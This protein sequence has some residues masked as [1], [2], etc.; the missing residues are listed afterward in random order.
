MLKRTTAAVLASLLLA[1]GCSQTKTPSQREEA[2]RN[3]N[4]ARAGVLI[5]LANDQFKSG[6]FEKCRQTID[7]ALKLAPDNESLHVLAAKLA[8]E[9]GQPEYADRE[10]ALARRLAPDDPEPYYLAGVI[11][12]RWQKYELAYELY[13][14]AS[15]KA[16][17]E[18]AYLLAEG[19]MLVAM[20]RL[21][22]AL[23]L[24]QEKVVY[25]EH[26]PT[27]RD[28]A[29]QLLLQA[30]RYR[31][32]V[33]MFRQA[34][35]LSE[36]DQ[37]VRERL[38]LAL[39]YAREFGESAEILVRLTQNDPYAKRS[40]LFLVLGE[41]QIQGGRPREARYSFQ[42][43]TQLDGYSAR[44]WQGLG[45]AALECGDLRRAEL[46]LQKATTLDDVPGEAHLLLGYVRLRQDRPVDA[47]GEFQK[48]SALDRRDTVSLCMMGY[49][50]EKGGQHEKAR[51]CYARALQL[52]PSDELA[53]QLMADVDLRGAG[54]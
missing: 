15:A 3:W 33:G 23:A 37:S 42:T 43:A 41:C 21:P 26:S 50:M 19:E 36:D 28:A 47:L 40:D 34:S 16:P 22:E 9:Q 38:A 53:K 24:L 10:L 7:S 6:N 11:Y 39:Y 46:A 51:E 32:A 2:T 8:I 52:R 18:L 49:A 12:Q 17:G 29:G 1:A 54:E 14:S 4:A 35:V 27:I 13:H 5:S 31:E 45:R 48:A 30:G 25:F 44:A 20:D